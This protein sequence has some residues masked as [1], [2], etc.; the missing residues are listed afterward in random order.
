M[1][2]STLGKG[3]VKVIHDAIDL[4]YDRLKARVLGGSW[5]DKR[6]HVGISPDLTLPGIFKQASVEERNRPN[7]DLL[8]SLLRTANG[9]LD[10]Q[11]IASKTKTVH[12][13]EAALREAE[14]KG[15]DHNMEDALSMEL[16]DVW[17]KATDDVKKIVDTEATHVR[18]T[19]TL[20]GILKVN[21]AS[22]I[23]DP[24]VFFIVVRDDSLC[25]E[26]RKLHLLPSGK[27]RVWKLSQVGHGYHKRGDENPKLGGLHPHC[28]CSLGTLLPGYG[29]DDAGMVHYISPDHD[30]YEAQNGMEKSEFLGKSRPEGIRTLED[31]RDMYNDN[32]M[33][34]DEHLPEP[35][36][37]AAANNSFITMNFP[38]DV[39]KN[40]EQSGR[41]H[42]LFETGEG[43]GETDQDER[44][45][46][47]ERA[48]GIPQDVHHYR[49]PIYGALAYRGPDQYFG[50]APTYGKAFVRLKPEVMPRSTFTYD[51]SFGTKI[52]DVR[53]HEYL[54]NVINRHMKR[55]SRG[56]LESQ[57]HGG[58][59]L[60]NDV[61]SIHIQPR[62][63]LENKEIE[64][65][66][67]LAMKYK[68]P[69]Y[70]HE[71]KGLS[72]P[73]KYNIHDEDSKHLWNPQHI[74]T[75]QVYDPAKH[76]E[77]D[78]A[79]AV[80]MDI[81]D[82]INNHLGLAYDARNTEPNEAKRHALGNFIIEG[83]VARRAME[84]PGL[85]KF[86]G[87]EP[88][89]AM[90]RKKN[91]GAFSFLD[92]NGKAKPRRPLRRPVS[93]EAPGTSPQQQNRHVE[94]P[95]SGDTH[96]SESPISA[97]SATSGEIPPG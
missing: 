87:H 26:C 75:R 19:G 56:Y 70:H 3:A 24:N 17:K 44:R 86:T 94:V 7:I 15:V 13:V 22:G 68:V 36:H 52:G 29:F 38:P 72:G 84:K 78:R 58:V 76:I 51:D 61:H 21:A 45:G 55:N 71:Y 47:E 2:K 9:Y 28:R 67:D 1:I 8:E 49:R 11:K 74:N 23:E 97:T 35:L 30:E 43:M 34:H 18:N 5:T 20:D 77:H 31:L 91:P 95:A 37:E 32:A 59:D 48:L 54:P 81:L 62:A 16:V 50:A 4:L 82:E 96:T 33:H 25:D 27:P 42:N 80:R 88:F 40:I 53:T 12:A 90:V 14:Q 10:A 93:A 66:M 85:L 39:A 92:K 83:N 57:I 41:F 64:N 73:S 60:A 6:V 63:S 65:L 89:V 79:E 69:L 46:V